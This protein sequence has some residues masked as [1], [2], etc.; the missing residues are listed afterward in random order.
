MK[1]A[2]VFLLVC[3]ALAPLA[4]AADQQATRLQAARALVNPDPAVRR[5]A[6]SQLA[7]VGRMGD[8]AALVKALRDSDE[9]TRATAEGAIWEIWGRSGDAEI[10]ALYKRGVELMN[11]G[12]A[13]QAIATF[14]LVINRKPEF[15]E[16][17]N[18][19]ATLYYSIGEYAKSLHDCDE[20]IKRNPLHFGALAGYGL[21]YTQMGQPERALDYFKRALKV[22][23]NMQGVARNIELLQKQTDDKRKNFI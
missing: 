12:A 5:A 9:E 17:W 20:V 21:I 15:A 22:N 8:V 1:V 6:V 4:D 3:I 16:G 7:E 19:R 2:A 13:G 23:P 14:T 18:K 11:F 10:D